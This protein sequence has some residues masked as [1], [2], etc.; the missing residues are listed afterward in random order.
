MNGLA[1]SVLVFY[2]IDQAAHERNLAVLA[3]RGDTA[4]AAAFL[5]TP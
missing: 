2:R 3:T 1:I 4:A 5:E